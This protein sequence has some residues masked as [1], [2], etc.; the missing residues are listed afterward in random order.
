MDY[1]LLIYFLKKNELRDDDSSITGKHT[2]LSV[3]IKK[4]ANGQNVFEL[5]E[6]PLERGHP[7]DVYSKGNDQ[8]VRPDVS[9]FDRVANEPSIMMQ[10]FHDPMDPFY[11]PLTKPKTNNYI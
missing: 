3:V 8:D 9:L 1:S 10:S 5:Q 4:N 6:V 7:S 2:R 11:D